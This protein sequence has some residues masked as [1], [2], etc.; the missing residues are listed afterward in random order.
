MSREDAQ[1]C[2]RRELELTR[3]PPPPLVPDMRAPDANALAWIEL[4]LSHPPSWTS[5]LLQPLITENK[6]LLFRNMKH[7]EGQT[8]KLFQAMMRFGAMYV[9]ARD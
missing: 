4:L 9:L 2:G 6:T 7:R 8:E 5:T 1:A 3:L